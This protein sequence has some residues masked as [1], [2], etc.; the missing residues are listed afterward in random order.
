[1]ILALIAAPLVAAGRPV[2]V[3]AAALGRTDAPL[4]PTRPAPLPAIAA[5]TVLLWF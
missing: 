5:F 2:A 4:A 3:F 1:M